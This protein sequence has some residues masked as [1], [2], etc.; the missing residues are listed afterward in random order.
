MGRRRNLVASVQEE[1]KPP[2]FVPNTSA[3]NRLQNRLRRFLDLQA[4]SIWHD[5]EQELA[6]ATGTVLDVGC[7]AQVYRHLLPAGVRYSGI[8]T[9]SAKA[10]F[11]YDVPDTRYFTGDDWGVAAGSCDM[12]L[13]TEVLEHI[14]DPAAFLAQARQ[15][16]RPGGRVVMTVPFAA[17]W[18]FIP[19][20]YWRF[21]PSGLARLLGAAGFEQINVHARGNPLTV[22]C[23][24]AMALPL[25]MTSQNNLAKRG[26]G[27]LLLP[28]VAVVA[29]IANLS[30]RSD[31]G[32]DCLGYTATARAREVD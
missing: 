16:L 25:M 6:T 3:S 7:G 18:H 24:K 29:T 15:C 8:D 20:D 31:W 14:P 13:F 1:F 5:L 2:V 23:Y 4:G 11:G 27:V 28:L 9:A 19:E 10:G 21:T 17:R 12:L 22:A 32:D 30:M 26:L